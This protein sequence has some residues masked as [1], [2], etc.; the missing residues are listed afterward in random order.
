MFNTV[1]SMFPI[2]KQRSYTAGF[3]NG[4]KFASI[5]PSIIKPIEGVISCGSGIPYKELIDPKKPFQFVGIVGRSDFNF[6]DLT[7]EQNIDPTLKKV[8][9]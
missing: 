4:A 3:G 2:H 6:N 9:G 7:E 5:I 1:Y 8:Y